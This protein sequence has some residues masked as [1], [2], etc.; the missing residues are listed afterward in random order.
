MR[1]NTVVIYKSKNGSTEKYARWISQELGC[2]AVRAEDF[3]KKDFEKY[4]NII[5]GG[6]V[7]AGGIMGFDLIKKNMRK[8]EGKK[9]V[10]FAVGLNIMG[11][12]Q[13][14]QLREINFDKKR[15]RGL[16][17]YYCPGAY[18]PKTVKGMDQGL[19]K[20]MVKMLESKKAEDT[21][22]ED[23]KLLEA[24]KKGADMV[25]RKYIEPIIAEFK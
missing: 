25:D 20:M 5:Y 19:M 3:S 16:T 21:T 12:E 24:V 22:P 6:W 18:D 13:R 10:L 7:H 9:I 1:D 4:D 14:I 17:C 15:V 23:I 8:L 11:Q 2:S